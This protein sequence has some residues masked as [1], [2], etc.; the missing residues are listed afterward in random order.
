MELAERR[1]VRDTPSHTAKAGIQG[2]R[3]RYARPGPAFAGMTS[4]TTSMSPDNSPVSAASRPLGCPHA[5]PRLPRQLEHRRHLLSRAQRLLCGAGRAGA[6]HA[7]SGARSRLEP[8]LHFQRRGAG[9]GGDGGRVAHR[10]QY[11]QSLRRAVAALRRAGG[12]GAGHGA[13]LGHAQRVAVPGRLRRA[14]RARLRHG[15]NPCGRHHRQPELRGEPG[16][17]RRRGHGRLDR[18][19]SCWWCPWWPPC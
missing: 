14:C 12:G 16:A 3:A 19:A 10:G 8:E 18:R 6:V 13:L 15:G 9:P 11:D 17:C 7:L 2:L 4:R 1:G 5:V